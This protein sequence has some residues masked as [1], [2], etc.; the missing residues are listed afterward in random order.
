[1][2]GEKNVFTKRNNLLMGRE[3]KNLEAEGWRK[4]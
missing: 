2:G 3:K 4:F 1:V